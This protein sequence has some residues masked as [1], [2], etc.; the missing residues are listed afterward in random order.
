M[1][2]ST[3]RREPVFRTVAERVVTS[4]N[5][6]LPTRSTEAP[7]AATTYLPPEL[8]ALSVPLEETTHELLDCCFPAGPE[9]V[10]CDML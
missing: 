4:T 10:T 2:L 5:G 9:G 1:P 8:L 3:A 6:T 7:H